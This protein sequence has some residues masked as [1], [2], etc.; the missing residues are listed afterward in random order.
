MKPIFQ[1]FVKLI[2]FMGTGFALLTGLAEFVVDHTFNLPKLLFSFIFFGGLMSLLFGISHVNGL[3]KLGITDFTAENLSPRQKR[4]IRSR[5]GVD[6]LVQK[7]KADPETKKLET[8]EH[9][10][11]ISFKTSFSKWTWGE[12]VTIHA[13]KVSDTET[14]YLIESRPQLKTHMVDSGRNLRNVMRVEK[15]LT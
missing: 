4:I 6:E 14:E 15:L 7:L 1:L 2:L 11:L 9:N 12:K 8:A 3:K 5:V 10:N 13:T